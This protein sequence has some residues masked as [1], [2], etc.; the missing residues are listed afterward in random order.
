VVRDLFSSVTARDI[1]SVKGR[2][3]LISFSSGEK[4]MLNCVLIISVYFCIRVLLSLASSA[5][6]FFVAS[7]GALWEIE[8]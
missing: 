8:V 4:S 5:R 7:V 2:L 3:V 1:A 6:D